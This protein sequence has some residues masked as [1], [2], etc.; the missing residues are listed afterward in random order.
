MIAV[1]AWLSVALAA[2]DGDRPIELPPSDHTL[3]YYNARLALRE[4]RSLEAVKLWWLRTALEDQTRTLSP[5]D[6]DFTSITWA[7]LGDLGVCAD[8]LPLDRD[9]V[10]LWPLA[11]HN[12]VVRNMGRRPKPARP[13]NFQAFE[14]SR[15]ARLVSLSDVLSYD[16]L[17]TVRLRKTPC[18]RPRTALLASG[19]PITA[20]LSDRQVA[21]RLLRYLIQQARETLARP[22]V[23]DRV[24]GRAALEARVFDLEL[25]LVELAARAARREALAQAREGRVRGLT[26][27]SIDAMREQAEIYQFGDDTEPARILRGALDWPVAEWM[28]L[29]SERR[30]FLFDHVRD[31]SES[32]GH[33]DRTAL[34]VIDTLL[35]AEEGA[36]VEAWIARH[37]ASQ[38]TAS[39]R[40]AI[41]GGARGQRLLALDDA[42][43]FQER[44]VIALHRGVDQL[45]RGD[46][47]DALR[48]FAFALQHARASRETDTVERL[49]RR[50]LS[51]VASQ[52]VISDELLVTLQEL[53]PRNDYAI[54]L[55]DLLWRAAFRADAASYQSGLDRQ[56]GRGAGTRRL[57]VLAPL[58]GRSQQD[59]YRLI[60][61]AKGEDIPNSELEHNY[62]AVEI[63]EIKAIFQRLFTVQETLLAVN[64]EY[65]RSASMDDAFRTEP[66]FKLQGSYRNM[67]KLAEKIVAAM[68]DE[69]LNR[70]IEDHY[71]GEA[72]TLTSGAETNMLKLKELRGTLSEDEA[73]RWDSI[74]KEFQRR[75]V[76]GGGDDDPVSRVTG[77]LSSLGGQLESIRNALTEAVQ[78]SAQ[79]DAAAAKLQAEHLAA[80]L[81]MQQESLAAQ[82]EA[83]AAQKA[84]AEANQASVEAQREAVEA[85]RISAEAQKTSAQ[86]SQESLQERRK[87]TL[88]QEQHV[89]ALPPPSAGPVAVDAPYEP[90]K[91][92]ATDPAWLRAHVTKL[93]QVLEAMANPQIQL[94]VNNQPPPGVEELLAQQVA[95]IERTLVPLVR[96]ATQKLDDREELIG[97]LNELLTRLG[98]LERQITKKSDPFGKPS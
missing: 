45:G 11:L 92:A 59:I 29:S 78:T 39:E 96:T 76:V 35:E 33:L 77:T 61:M 25:Q 55:E 37:Y 18:L 75:A 65:I 47:E 89:A 50:W 49:S 51:F 68:N 14:V 41:W 19:Q 20:E 66:P 57:E 31:Y 8:G 17:K 16:E 24:R 86:L 85:Q 91:D 27:E 53:V 71:I 95:I 88:V 43:G 5:H 72:Q 84:S 60:K 97:K 44:S 62:S 87:Q 82:K 63:N 1:A 81:K 90:P 12:W 70:L 64:A 36:E 54:L 93:E 69:E 6:A 40:E 58:A 74:K 21:G 38:Q 48:S 52:F 32:H 2:G 13:N 30:R 23:A 15:Q 83:V 46:R 79:N 26:T 73:A 28:T 22:A 34:G 56:L 80:Q 42:S 94:E 67:N 98:I 10:G 4:G 3:V 9:G 7:A